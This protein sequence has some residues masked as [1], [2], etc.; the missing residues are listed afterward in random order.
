MQG[1][2]CT[3]LR[4]WYGRSVPSCKGQAHLPKPFVLQVRTQLE[5]KAIRKVIFVPGKI[6]N[7]IIGK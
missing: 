7:I 6:M 5:G 1:V 4:H 2:T 3:R